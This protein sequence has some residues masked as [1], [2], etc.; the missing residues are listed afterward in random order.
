ML[1]VWEA[2]RLPWFR[3][4]KHWTVFII[5]QLLVDAWAAIKKVVE[6]IDAH[7]C[8][9]YQT[10]AKEESKQE[11]TCPLH[12]CYALSVTRQSNRSTILNPFYSTLQKELPHSIKYSW[13]MHW[14][15]HSE[16]QHTDLQQ[17]KR[18]EKNAPQ[19]NNRYQL[20]WCKTFG[21]RFRRYVYNVIL[22]VFT[23]IFPSI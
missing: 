21:T 8:R 12:L 16:R 1:W 19:T 7:D 23:A 10:V 6:S 18:W 13:E 20:F 17:H 14:C 15:T 11:P 2:T 4:K 5:Y 22:A 9:C 3:K